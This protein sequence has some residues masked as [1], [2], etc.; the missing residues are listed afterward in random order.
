MHKVQ[1]SQFKDGRH[2][3]SYYLDGRRRR[4][5]FAKLRDAQNRKNE[6]T[7]LMGRGLKVAEESKVAADEVAQYVSRRLKESGITKPASSVIDE[8]IEAC[9]QLKDGESLVQA[10]KVY[11]GISGTFTNA[12]GN[13]VGSFSGISDVIGSNDSFP[14]YNN[15][16]D[17]L[18]AKNP[19]SLLIELVTG[20]DLGTVKVTLQV[21][22]KCSCPAGTKP[23]E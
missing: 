17:Y 22:N 19:G 1:L 8:Y 12:S 9:K 18:E 21:P 23:V 13:Q 3:L 4:E 2:C 11:A 14:R 7:R 15:V 20:K 6:V 10:C 16:R 5:T